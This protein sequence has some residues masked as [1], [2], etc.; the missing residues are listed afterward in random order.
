MELLAF[1]LLVSPRWRV[2]ARPVPW[3]A[4][5][6]LRQQFGEHVAELGGGDGLGDRLLA[7]GERGPDLDVEPDGRMV[8]DAL[9]RP[10]GWIA[11]HL[12]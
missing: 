8:A 4:W 10:H 6:L 1:Y 9:L 3:Q 2:F 12:H 11:L 7:P 5:Y